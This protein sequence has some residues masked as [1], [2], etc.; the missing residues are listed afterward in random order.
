MPPK[1]PKRGG[2]GSAEI[3]EQRVLRRS[4]ERLIHFSSTPHTVLAALLLLCDIERSNIINVIEGVRYG[5]S[6]EQISAF[7]KY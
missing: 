4:A 2:A 1:Y 7:L 6:P 5:L 3:S